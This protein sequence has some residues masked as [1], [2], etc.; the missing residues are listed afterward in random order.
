MSQFRSQNLDFH[1]LPTQL[2]I[3]LYIPLFFL[4]Y[5]SNECVMR[6]D[7]I[8]F[9]LVEDFVTFF[10]FT[11]TFDVGDEI[12]RLENKEAIDILELQRSMD[13]LND[14]QPV[15]PRITFR[16]AVKKLMIYPDSSTGLMLDGENE[17]KGI[18]MSCLNRFI[19]ISCF[20]S[21]F[22]FVSTFFCLVS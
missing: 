10:C 17:D 9:S 16:S 21:L 2:G 7:I 6:S 5:C 13:E 8:F 3:E 15:H 11:D 4:A 22:I 1:F 18:T 14:N 20:N 12:L 19:K